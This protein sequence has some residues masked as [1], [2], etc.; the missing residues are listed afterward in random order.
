MQRMEETISMSKEKMEIWGR[1]LEME[2]RYDCYSGEEVLDSQKE[3]LAEFLRAED[4]IEASLEEVKKYCLEQNGGEIGD[5][6][7]TNI[8]KFVAP[9]YLY[10]ARDADKHIVAV[11]CNYKF[12]QENGIAVVF[13]D[14]KFNRIGRQDIVL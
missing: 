8:F 11:M 2:V 6:A 9:K 1:E 7:I 10:V 4:G 12:D 3:A 5:S 14:G 13:E